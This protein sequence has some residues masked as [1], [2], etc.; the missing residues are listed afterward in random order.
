[1][2]Y[3][4]KDYSRHEN[5]FIFGLSFKSL[6]LILIFFG[7]GFFVVRAKFIS[8]I[9]KIIILIPLLAVAL[10][11]IFYKT[12]EGD[13]FAV[14]ILNLVVYYASPKFLIYKKQTGSERRDMSGKKNR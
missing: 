1:M 13:D 11:T 14:Y 8:W 5:K 6:A 9:L 4:P 2:A 3:L 7:L 12:Q 10:F